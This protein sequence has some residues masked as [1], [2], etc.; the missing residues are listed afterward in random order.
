M[1][2]SPQFHII[3]LLFAYHHQPPP[4]LLLPS[5]SSSVSGF[6]LDVD[7]SIT[8][9]AQIKIRNQDFVQDPLVRTKCTIIYLPKS[10]AII[11]NSTAAADWTIT[12]PAQARTQHQSS[13]ADFNVNM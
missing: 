10:L 13:R 4:L 3:P 9:S 12:S 5:T 2:K 8:G 11:R 6:D 1:E 7:F